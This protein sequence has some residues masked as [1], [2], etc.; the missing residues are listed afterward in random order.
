MKVK[1][2]N[3]TWKW[4]NLSKKIPLD[5]II[6]ESIRITQ[7]P[8]ETSLNSKIEYAQSGLITARFESKLTQKKKEKLLIKEAL[9]VNEETGNQMPNNNNPQVNNNTNF[10]K[11]KVLE[12]EKKMQMDKNKSE[13][14]TMKNYW[15]KK[16][17]EKWPPPGP[18]EGGGRSGGQRL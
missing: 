13:A 2:L 3:G 1:K 7:R 9:K 5:R 18:Q 12:I 10:V 15:S 17:D 11:S 4:S 8:S 6:Y 16:K 14:N